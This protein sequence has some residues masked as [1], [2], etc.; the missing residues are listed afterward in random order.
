MALRSRPD[1]H[2]ALRIGA[3]SGAL[4]GRYDEARRLAARLHEIDPALRAS[5]LST[6]LGPYRNLEHVAMY[7]DGLRKAGLTD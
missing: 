1:S 3:A 7:A 5:T 2:A 4:A 6:V